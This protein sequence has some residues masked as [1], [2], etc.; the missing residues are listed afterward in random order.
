[1][2]DKA[3]QVAIGSKRPRQ[4]SPPFATIPKEVRATQCGILQTGSYGRNNKRKKWRYDDLEGLMADKEMFIH[5]LMDERLIAKERLCPMCDERITLT[6]CADQIYSS[7]KAGSRKRGKD[8]KQRYRSG[9]V[10]GS[11]KAK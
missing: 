2:V 4:T 3:V 10:A 7:G 11:R 6:R 1:M 9:K 5:W 8:T